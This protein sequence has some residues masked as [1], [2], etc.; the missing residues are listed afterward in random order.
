[1][2]VDTARAAG[3]SVGDGADGDP[4][5]DGIGFAVRLSPAGDVFIHESGVEQVSGNPNNVFATYASGDRIRVTFTD[6]FDGTTTIGYFLIPAACQ[7]PLCQGMPLR[8][9]GPA[10]YPLRVDAS[11]RTPGAVLDDV[12]VVRIK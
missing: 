12:R 6:N 3:L 4:T 2:A 5:L 11:L 9:A 7:G 1:V 10:S 8:T